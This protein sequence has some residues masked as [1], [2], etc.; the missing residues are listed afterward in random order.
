MNISISQKVDRFGI[1]KGV[2]NISLSE[3]EAIELLQRTPELAKSNPDN[4]SLKTI[5][6]KDKEAL[7]DYLY[8]KHRQ[9]YEM[10]S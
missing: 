3:E 6:S 5:T 8:K 7:A 9:L 10:T 2:L 4:L 1:S